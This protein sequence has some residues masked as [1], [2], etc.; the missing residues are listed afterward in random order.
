MPY[1]RAFAHRICFFRFLQ[2]FFCSPICKFKK[3]VII[4]RHSQKSILRGLAKSYCNFFDCKSNFF[5]KNLCLI[6]TFLIVKATFLIYKLLFSPF[7]GLDFLPK[8]KK[9]VKREANALFKGI[10]T[11]NLFFSIF[12][13]IFLSPNL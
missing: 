10:C 5:D 9:S 11:P 4:C 8:G 3:Y 13:K 12:A 1:L 6:V 7:T 2:K